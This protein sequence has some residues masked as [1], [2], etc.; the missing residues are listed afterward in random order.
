MLLKSS[1]AV[2][3]QQPM[4]TSSMMGAVPT[5]ESIIKPVSGQTRLTRNCSTTPLRISDGPRLHLDV[6]LEEIP[7]QLSDQHYCLLV[8][9]FSAFKLRVRAERFKRWRPAAGEPVR[10]NAALWWRFCIDATVDGI[11]ARNR[12]R[13]LQFALKKAR[14][15]VAYVQGYTQ[16]LTEVG[17]V[18][19]MLGGTQGV[20][21]LRGLQHTY[22][23]RV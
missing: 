18:L 21:G 5:I 20:V 11:R 7:I 13:S 10:G 16:H 4:T 9:L 19:C 8:K 3:Q 17:G 23:S 1:E 12:R 14:R 6:R 22:F 15:N 2:A